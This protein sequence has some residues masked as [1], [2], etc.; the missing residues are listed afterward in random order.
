MSCRKASASC[1]GH[2]LVSCRRPGPLSPVAH[3][4]LPTFCPSCVQKKT[5]VAFAGRLWSLFFSLGR[6]R[7]HLRGVARH[8]R[9]ASALGLQA[10]CKRAAHHCRGRHDG[11]KD[12][13]L[14]GPVFTAGTACLLLAAALQR[15]PVR[16]TGTRVPLCLSVCL[17]WSVW[18]GL[19]LPGTNNQQPTANAQHPAPRLD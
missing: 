17:I 9:L 3:P 15:G 12:S 16:A 6:P 10:V 2:G 18:P 11:P 4:I 5:D 13:D 1:R 14:L 7:P 19:P 8:H